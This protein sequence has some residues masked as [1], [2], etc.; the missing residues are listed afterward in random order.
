MT[1][2][3]AIHAPVVAPQ[4]LATQEQPLPLDG[5][6]IERESRLQILERA[7]ID[8]RNNYVRSTLELGYVLRE[9]MALCH[10]HKERSVELF[11]KLG[12]T[13][14]T[15]YRLARTAA[16]VGQMPA[17]KDLADRQY[18]HVLTLIEGTTEDQ[19]ALIAADQ[20]QELPLDE[21]SRM[22]VRQLRQRLR[23]L[24]DSA[25]QLVAEETKTLRSERDALAEDLEAARAALASDAKATRKTARKLREQI[26]AAADIGETL[27]EQIAALEEDDARRIWGEL[28]NA[29]S[30]GSMRLKALW[31]AAQQRAME[32][33]L[34]D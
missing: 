32:L 15:G 33:G 21:I 13:P 6:L 22:S 9:H 25:S 17:L 31:D 19:L 18:S 28:E 1:Q 14:S 16:M 7:A 4:G 8:C 24:T 23:K 12:L 26:Q 2:P 27:L 34:E 11:D 5:D 20:L 3:A 30:S 29:I 10:D